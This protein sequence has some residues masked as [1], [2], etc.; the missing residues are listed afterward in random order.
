VKK[1]LL[2]AGTVVL[3]A[4]AAILVAIAVNG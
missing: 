3:L 4:A 2:I 1:W